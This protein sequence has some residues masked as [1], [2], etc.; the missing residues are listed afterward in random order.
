MGASFLPHQ[1][2]EN[3]IPP[4]LLDAE[5]QQLRP[6]LTLL[7]SVPR[8]IL[9]DHGQKTDHAFFIEERA[10]SATNTITEYKGS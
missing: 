10:V 7:R 4:A 3:R 1:P 2:V 9:I 5:L 6:H 8:E